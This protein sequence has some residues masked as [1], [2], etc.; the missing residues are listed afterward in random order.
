MELLKQRILKEGRILPGNIVS[1]SSF[2][3]HMVDPFLMQE[4]G[5]EFAAI[6]RGQKPTKIMTAEASGIPMAAFTALA[7]DIPFI[8]AKK[9]STINL[10]ETFYSAEVFSQ[11]RQVSVY[12]R[13]SKEFLNENDRILIIDDFLA[14]GSAVNGLYKIIQEAKATLIGVGI[15]I[16][17]S[18]QEGA[19]DLEAKHINL[20]SL[21]RVKSLENGVITLF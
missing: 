17:K 12:I 21:A 5:K 14:F 15:C 20:H 13:V 19:A 16:E 6:F 8:I 4:I 1:V 10:T 18:F 7:L 11:T 9:Y 2:L 3:N